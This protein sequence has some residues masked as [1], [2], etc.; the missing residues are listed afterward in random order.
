[1]S[2]IVNYVRESYSEMKKVVWP[3]RESVLE[4]TKIVIIS[5]VIVALFLFAVDFLASKIVADVLAGNWLTGG[6]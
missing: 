4:N 6:K 2:K 3:T 1:M 5:L